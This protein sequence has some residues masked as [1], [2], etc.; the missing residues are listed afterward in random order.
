MPAPL[1]ADEYRAMIFVILFGGNDGYNCVI[2]T[3]ATRYAEYKNARATLAISLGSDPNVNVNKLLNADGT[4]SG[5]GLNPTLKPLVNIWNA[6]E[7]NIIHNVGPV[8][9]P[10]N[11]ILFSYWDGLSAYDSKISDVNY[12]PQGLFAHDEQASAW[13]NATGNPRNPLGW[14]GASAARLGNIPESIVDALSFTGNTTLGNGPA[15]GAITLP[16]YPGGPPALG[17]STTA[18]DITA[19]S[20]IASSQVNNYLTKVYGAKELQSIAID[21]KFGSIVQAPPGSA[22]VDPV[23]KANYTALGS[24][25]NT[26]CFQ[27]LKALTLTRDKSQGNRHI[28]IIGQGGYDTHYQQ[29]GP[30]IALL[31]DLANSLSL[32][33]KTIKDLGLENNVAIATMS[34]FGRTT[35]ENGSQGT[36]H[37][38][39]NEQFIIGGSGILKGGRQFGTIGDYPRYSAQTQGGVAYTSDESFNVLRDPTNGKA[40]QGRWIPS[41]SHKQYGATMM[42]WLNPNFTYTE[43]NEIF[44]DLN[45][46]NFVGKPS[47]IG[48]SGPQYY[49]PNSVSVWR[50]WVSANINSATADSGYNIFPGAGTDRRILSLFKNTPLPI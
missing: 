19:F 21:K 27:V 40:T 36:D 18:N 29:A 2:P 13:Q 1:Y 23:I 38:W 41:I 28:F 39:G 35:I 46:W 49:G 9:R 30:H 14:G 44:P 45:R 12:F 43:L 42:N 47:L 37:G 8:V 4:D 15:G 48:P 33:W 25:F 50:S 24:T 7:M 26:Q 31:T 32:L 3:D 16:T 11:Q 17:G 20:A 6:G 34:E 5:Y 10:M 22:L